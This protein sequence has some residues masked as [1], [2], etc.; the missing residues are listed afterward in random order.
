MLILD[1]NVVSEVRKPSGNRNVKTWL[2]DQNGDEM[3]ISAITVLELQRG[4]SQS[5]KRGDKPQA[6]MLARW[7]DDMLLPTFAGRILPVDHSIARLAGRLEWP[8]PADFRDA[9]IAATAIE[10]GATVVTR[11]V[12]HFE[13]AGV[14]LVNPWVV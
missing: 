6:T 12:R 3:Y 2:S 1:T 10:H 7:L 11:N 9:L 4:I 8:S 14:D 13:G 5:E